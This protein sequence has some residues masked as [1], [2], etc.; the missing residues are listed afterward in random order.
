ML[1]KVLSYSERI[2]YGVGRKFVWVFDSK[3]DYFLL[4]FFVIKF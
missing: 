3:F 2:Y 4:K 1:V